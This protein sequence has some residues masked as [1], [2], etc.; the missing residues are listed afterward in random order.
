M[1]RRLF[2]KERARAVAPRL[3][4]LRRRRADGKR[5]RD[6]AANEKTTTAAAKIETAGL[7]VPECGRDVAAAWLKTKKSTAPVAAKK[8]RPRRSLFTAT[9]Q[10]VGHALGKTAAAIADRVPWAGTGDAVDLL[11]TDHRR[12]EDLLKTGEETTA[13]A[14]RRRAEILNTIATELTA[15]ELIEE[16]LFYPA[17]KPHAEA[18][19]IVLEGY[20]EHHVADVLLKELHCLPPSDERWGAKFKVLKESLEHHIEEE[21]GEMFKTARSVLSRA[22]LADLAAKMEEMKTAALSAGT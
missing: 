18:K 5:T 20:Q 10:A 17:L 13:R 4:S 22:Q 7:V 3:L 16:K 21:E 11:E 8:A 12:L 9:A 2:R 14:V 19:A 15:H 1:L 6:G